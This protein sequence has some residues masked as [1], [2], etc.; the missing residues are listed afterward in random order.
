[1]TT[2]ESTE[3][4]SD[5]GVKALKAER[6]ARRELKKEF[7]DFRAEVDAAKSLNAARFLQNDNADLKQQ[8]EIMTLEK[9]LWQNRAKINGE[10]CRRLRLEL[11][12]AY[13]A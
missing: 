8:L 11:E 9:T 10:K 2:E 7:D 13:N 6:A 5:G 3:E 1:M 4:L 12:D